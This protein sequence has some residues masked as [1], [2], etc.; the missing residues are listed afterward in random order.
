VVDP[1]ARAANAPVEV[2]VE[3]AGTD[4]Q[5]RAEV[6]AAEGVEGAEATVVA[7][8]ARV[9]VDSVPPEGHT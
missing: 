9:A 7:E 3:V 8:G 1:T 4:A 5:V 2:I 6:E